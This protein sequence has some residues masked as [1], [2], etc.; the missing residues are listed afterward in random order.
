MLT[1]ASGQE[2]VRVV[3][4]MEKVPQLMANTGVGGFWAA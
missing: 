4:F 2:A 1:H 3:G